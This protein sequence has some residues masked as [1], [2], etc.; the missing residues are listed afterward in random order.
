MSHYVVWKAAPAP[1][2]WLWSHCL[3]KYFIPVRR[4]RGGVQ[5]LWE[6]ENICTTQH[7]E[8]CIKGEKKETR[9]SRKDTTIYS[10][11]PPGL[12]LFIVYKLQ[13]PC[14][15]CSFI[16]THLKTQQHDYHSK[17]PRKMVLVKVLHDDLSEIAICWSAHEAFLHPDVQSELT[18]SPCADFNAFAYHL[19]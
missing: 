17:K 9:S 10:A 8:I 7:N 14:C 15:P 16:L 4:R 12:H 6:G 1:S 18:L 5:T 13:N 11:W 19:K 2:W 3:N